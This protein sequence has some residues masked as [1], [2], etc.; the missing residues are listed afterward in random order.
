MFQSIADDNEAEDEDSAAA[1]EDQ[2]ASNFAISMMET[3]S[4]Q[5]I[6]S[7]PQES[8]ADT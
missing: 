8:P 2:S 5:L 3:S 7:A 1:L 4:Q 6:Y